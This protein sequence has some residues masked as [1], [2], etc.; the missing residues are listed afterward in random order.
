MAE[1]NEIMETDGIALDDVKE[2]TSTE[3]VDVGNIVGYVM[4]RFKKSED[5]LY[6]ALRYGIMSRPRF[7]IF[8]YDPTMSKGNNMPIADSTFGY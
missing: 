4:G 3:D 7:S 5:H 8:D 1:E 2:E 6:D